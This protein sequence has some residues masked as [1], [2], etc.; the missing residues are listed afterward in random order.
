MPGW[1]VRPAD[2]AQVEQLSRSLGI[3]RAIARTLWLRGHATPIQVRAFF[4]SRESLAFLERPIVTPGMEKA[5]A[6]IKEAVSR[7][8]K[9]AIYGDYDCDGI[10][11]TALLFRYLKRGLN[12]DVSAT[13]PDRFKDGYGI[14]P[15][16]IEKMS[17]QGATLILT[18]DNGISAIEAAEKAKILGIDLIVTDH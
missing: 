4:E 12:A 14:T 18:C 13:L 15:R 8:E 5:V 11:S 1:N 3:H 7:K 10:T 17:A 9:I 6:R 2:S 16:A